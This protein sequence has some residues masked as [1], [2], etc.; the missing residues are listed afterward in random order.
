MREQR[1]ADDRAA[2]RG[3]RRRTSWLLRL[4]LVLNLVGG[5]MVL[6]AG[7]MLPSVAIAAYDDAPDLLGHAWAT[8]LSAGL[9]LLL[10]VPTYRWARRTPV[11]HRE[12]F[13]IVGIGWLASGLIGA[14]PY[15]LYAHLAPGGL[16]LPEVVA[17]GSDFC[18]YTAAA[19]E[20]ISGIT[21]T[22]ASNITDGLWGDTPGETPDGRAGLPRGILLWRAMTHYLGGM[23]MIVLGVAI[24]PLLGVGGMQLLKAELPGPSPDKLAP[25]VGETAAILWKVYLLFSAVLFMLL[26]AGG[27][28][29]FEAICHAMST[30]ATGGFSTR[31][32]SVGGFGSAYFEWVITAF[33]W[34]G[35]MSFTLHFLALQGR[36]RAYWE[37][38]EWRAYCGICL[39]AITV[40]AWSLLNADQG[41]GFGEALRMAAFQTVAIITTSGFASVDYEQWT[42]APTA[43]LFITLLKFVGGCAGSTSGGFKVVRH[44][45]LAKMWMR[46][47]FFLNHPRAVRPV[48]L[49]GRAVEPAV[50]RSV[51]GFAGAY[52][53]LLVLGTIF[54]S[55]DGQDVQTA[56]TAAAASLGNVGPGLGDVG[57]HD[58]Y[59]VLS[60]QSKWVSM[61][62]MV[63]GRL[64]IYTLLMLVTPA[65]WRR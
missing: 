29:A 39:V 33:M 58:N 55:L 20:S 23:G 26:S 32:L 6:L 16:C 49:G 60:T 30:M 45:L 10:F 54:F 41:F 48:R 37:D 31:A 44:L 3:M 36:L 62:L 52:I 4:G 51:A 35:G 46:E 5:L 28:D 18:S 12:G 19:F 38:P 64:E 50:I 59:A 9:G 11:G 42:Y 14:L 15:W 47:L 61:T 13:L 56:F 53:A 8:G 1:R 24:L 57:P 40:I 27:M 17:V 22:G 7:A 65:F 34:I 2:A 43:L 25:R 21:T 63:F